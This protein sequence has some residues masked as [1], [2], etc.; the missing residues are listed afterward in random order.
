MDPTIY[1]ELNRAWK[2]TCRVILG[3]EV[4]ELKEYEEWLSEYLPQIGKG[5]SHISGKDVTLA[6]TDYCKTANFVSADEM[7]EISVP[8]SINEIKDIDSI[9]EA[10]SG[11]WEYAGDRTLGKSSHFEASDFIVDSH[12]VYQ[13]VD[14]T[15]SQY[16][17]MSSNTQDSK[18][19]FGCRGF[20]FGEFGIAFVKGTRMKRIIGS[21]LGFDSSDVYFSANTIACHDIMFSFNQMNKR[22][23]I[24]NFELPKD[25]Y[26]EIKKKLLKE[27]V[28]ELKK[29]KRFPSIVELVPKMKAGREMKV[30]LSPAKR[31]NDMTPIERAFTS[32]S[33][34]LLKKE[35]TDIT[36]YEPWLSRHVSVP[37]ELKSPFGADVM[38]SA[39]VAPM[40]SLILSKG[41][42]SIEE[43]NKLGNVHL[44]EN[45]VTSLSKIKDGLSKIGYITTE[46]LIGNNSNVIKSPIIFNDMNIY[47][48]DRALTSESSAIG[49]LIS[50]SK[51]IFGSN[52]VSVSQ[53]CMNCYY[54]IRLTRCFE[55]DVSADCTDAYFCHNSEGLNE[56]MF[57][58][59][60]K[61]KRYA[62]GNTELPQDQ[63][64]KVRDMLVQ[65]MADEL[66]KKKELKWDI[67][68]IGCRRH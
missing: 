18:Y 5:K 21:H 64:R 41:L 22:H 9:I 15:G 4:G 53:F 46:I 35:L 48:V 16:I 63:Y 67:Y 59:N 33:K 56:A 31:K 65:Q 58:W 26:A 12:Y 52:K 1:A 25:K 8:L 34:V 66:D 23:C 11:R 49:Y 6:M 38:F 43:A 28:E 60:V 17:H 2:S 27:V 45:D 13:G 37:K 62:I 14:V 61:S 44:D 51:Y 3:D 36:Q 19:V 54:S 29:N 7:K 30:E 24:G 40:D 68:N 47:R 20:F 32:T 50:N 57:C 10:I 39:L 42:V 55:V